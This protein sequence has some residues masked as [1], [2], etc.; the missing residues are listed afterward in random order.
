MGILI[1]YTLVLR[2]DHHSSAESR[3]QCFAEPHVYLLRGYT[4][5]RICRGV[6][7]Q[8]D[9][10]RACHGGKKKCQ[11]YWTRHCLQK[12]TSPYKY[13]QKNFTITT[14]SPPILSLH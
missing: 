9:G 13:M 12:K 7:P 3:I 2:I 6:R 14:T 8:Q 10:M 1:I 4:Q 11:A 5:H